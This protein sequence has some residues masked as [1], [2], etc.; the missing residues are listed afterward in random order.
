MVPAWPSH[1]FRRAALNDPVME[2]PYRAYQSDPVMERPYEM[3][4]ITVYTV[5]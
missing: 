5:C 2:R 3:E 1:S 4:S